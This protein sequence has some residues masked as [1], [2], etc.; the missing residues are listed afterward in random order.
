M[1]PQIGDQVDVEFLD[2]TKGGVARESGRLGVCMDAAEKRVTHLTVETDG[3]ATFIPRERVI[4]VVMSP[5][6]RRALA[7]DLPAKSLR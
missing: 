2:T 5:F 1:T 4:S 3:G 7:G 6:T